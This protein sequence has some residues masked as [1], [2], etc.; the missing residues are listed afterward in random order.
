MRATLPSPTMPIGI[1]LRSV[2][3]KRCGVHSPGAALR[4]VGL[5]GIRFDTVSSITSVFATVNGHLP[6][7]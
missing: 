3:I 7:D 4:A 1:A 5:G 2:P 6:P